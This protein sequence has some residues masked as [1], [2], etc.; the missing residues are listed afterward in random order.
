MAAFAVL[1]LPGVAHASPEDLFGYG[2]RGPAMGGLGVSMSRGAEAAYYNPALLSELRQPKLTLGFAGAT[3]RLRA[4]GDAVGG[5]RSVDAQASRGVL[6]GAE[7]P[8]PFG[9]PLRNRIGMALAFYTPSDVVVRGR[10]LYPERPQ[11]PILPD[12]AQSATLRFGLGVDL[13]HG[14]EVGAGFAALAEL[15]GT[16]VV[17]TESTG[18]IGARVEDQLVA[19]YA[20]TFG[21]SYSY[22]SRSNLFRFGAVF[23]GKL[24]AR[25]SV[26]IDATRFSTISLPRFNIAGLAQYDP[27]Q[28]ALEASWVRPDRTL[29]VSLTYKRWSR[30][31]GP[32]EPTVLCPDDDPDCGAL[33]PPRA[34]YNDTVV[35]RVGVEQRVLHHR[36]VTLQVR[37]GAFFEPTPLSRDLPSGQAYDP[38]QQA[39]TA[40]PMLHFDASRLGLTTGLGVRFP[41]APFEVDL[42]AQWHALLPREQRFAAAQG[43]GTATAFGHVLAFG[44][45]TGVRF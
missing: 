32:L 3:F 4:E 23:R 36:A 26:L 34:E 33:V 41:R 9:G 38:G 40:S 8:L 24:D 30:F 14:F 22:Q 13:G 18:K 44:M 28:A 39:T 10:I 15:I 29:G 43:A 17:A 7:T 5:E 42:Y 37:G 45:T 12:R 19:T 21:A 16:V 20:P 35:V 25:F 6:I 11:Y 2:T 31:P 1:S 27:A